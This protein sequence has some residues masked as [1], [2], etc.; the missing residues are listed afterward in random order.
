MFD[1]RHCDILRKPDDPNLY[2]LGRIHNHNVVIVCLPAGQTGASSAAAV[3]GQMRCQFTSIQH[4]FLVGVGGGVPG[5]DAAVRLGDVVISQPHMGHGGVVQYDF[6][7]STPSGF[8]R[9]GFVNAPP[10]I[11]LN[12]VS[13]LRANILEHQVH[14]SK[15][16]STLRRLRD[17]AGPDI[18]F[19]STYKHVG[20]SSCDSCDKD[21]VIHGVPRSSEDIVIHYGTIASGNQLIRD[22]ITRD[23]LSSQLGGV[24]CFEMEAAGFMSIF[25][26][27]VI[28]GICDYAD[29]HKSKKWQ[30]YA[31]ATA[32]IIAK[33]ILSILPI[34]QLAAAEEADFALDNPLQFL[35]L[36]KRPEWHLAQAGTAM[37]ILGDEEFLAWRKKTSAC[38]WLSGKIGSGKTFVTT[39]VVSHLIEASQKGG[40]FVAHFFYNHSSKFRLK[41]I[42]L[43]ESY[44]K[45]IL[46]FLEKTGHVCPQELVCA[47][48]RFYGPNRC[49]PSF[50]EIIERIFIPLGDFLTQLT[51][52]STYIVDG[53]DECESCER[54]LVLGTFR[55]MVQQRDA[56][57]VFISGRE[58]LYVTNFIEDSTT[59]RISNKDNKD[60]IREFIEWKVEAKLRE[61][62]LTENEY[63]LQDIKR[64]LNEKAD[65]IRVLWV[66]MQ[67]D[68]LWDECST[69]GDIQTALENLPR[70][71]DETY[72]R[73]LQRINKRQSRFAWTILRWVAAAITPF[74]V[75]QLREGLAINTNT[76]CLDRNQIPP[77]QEI[78][79]CCC[80]LITSNNGQILLTH[81]SVRQFLETRLPSGQFTCASFELYTAQSELG[82]LCVTHLTSADYGLGLQHCNVGECSRI[83][84]GKLTMKTLIEGPLPSW[85]HR[86]LPRPK[87]ATIVLPNRSSNPSSPS[88]TEVLSFFQYAKAHWAPLTRHITED[89]PNWD[90][91]RALALEPNLSWRLHPWQPLGESLDSH[92]SGLLGWAV[93]NHHVPLLHILLGLR[94]FKPKK[95]IFNVPFYHYDSLP[96]LHLASITGD[97]EIVK[98]LLQVCDLNK[99]DNNHRTSLHHAAERGHSDVIPLLIQKQGDLKVRDS[100]GRTALHFAAENGHERAVQ[101]LIDQGADVDQRD[102][103]RQT[104]IFLA[105]RNGH[106][107]II[108]TL[109]DRGADVNMQDKNKW[110]P[111][112]IAADY[113]RDQ[114]VRTL[115]ELGADINMKDDVGR[116][117]LDIAVTRALV[118]LS[119]DVDLNPI[120]N[121]A[122]FLA[123][124]QGNEAVLRVL[125]ACGEAVDGKDF[126]GWTP[127]MRAAASGH[128][129]VAKLLLENGA[130]IEANDMEYGW[131]PLS[132]A[133]EREQVAMIKLLLENGAD[134]EARHS[135]SRRTPLSW[136]V[137]KAQEAI[138]KLLLEKGAKIDS[139][140]T[141]Y[142]YTPLLWAVKKG[143]EAIINLLLE[144][145]ANVDAKDQFGRTPLSRAAQ[146]GDEATAKLLLE[147]G[148]KIEV[149]DE[150]CQT[151]LSQAI[152]A[153]N[154][155]MIEL[156]LEKG[157]HVE[158]KDWDIQMPFPSKEGREA[159]AELL[160]KKAADIKA[161]DR[162]HQTLL[163]QAAQ[164]GGA[165]I[166]KLLLENGADIEVKDEFR[167]TPLSRAATVGNQA[168]TKL[169]LEKGAHIETR[170]WDN[171]TPLSWAAEGGH[172]TVTELLL[173]KGA[174]IEA[175]DG[176]YNQTP[177]S[178]AARHGQEAVT[179]LLLEKGADFE[180]KDTQYN[181]TPLSW[182]AK[183]G[184]EAVAKLLLEKG[185]Y[186]QAKDQSGRTPLSW[187]VQGGHE[188]VVR[189]LLD[190]GADVQASDKNGRTPV[191]WAYIGGHQAIVK[192]LQSADSA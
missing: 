48:K 178:L 31:A 100:R 44:I 144:K 1:E 164:E 63:V 192:L 80:N 141:E 119:G 28:R 54:R 116:K 79:K 135:G 175:K 17:S 125:L 152:K 73:C 126:D 47:V 109:V 22:G 157:A 74:Q 6:G 111:L 23:T 10:T 56:Q 75:D 97:V 65:L 191:S 83:A 94:D 122:I 186:L 184:H 183:E 35:N 50:A 138:I 40:D 148:A 62:Q 155:A 60:D 3:M 187:A 95:D 127:L 149:K 142:S 92:Y 101:A 188:A 55:N 150:F 134:I 87:P 114:T 18:L 84:M 154:M 68:A 93:V 170:D 57:R 137:E 151:P 120:T 128:E 69:D 169:L 133:I 181:Q 145:G 21:L 45:Q 159:V 105:A 177:L 15:N 11:L 86:F 52:S 41:A 85:T 12:A 110:T 20:G 160:L 115:I 59:L 108:Q 124:Q 96:A 29:S 143:Q 51:P 26:G 46:G 58:D 5:D 9:T 171:R 49:H 82:A 8:I 153:G 165:V 107:R 117:A 139:E 24:L 19:Q 81:H 71:L 25:P 13:K 130:N 189:L 140:D 64:K 146:E 162:L 67:I 99:R 103:M 89:S 104:A 7:K 98:R 78:I 121:Q 172:E 185:A 166:T 72:A 4:T 147:K 91:F 167:Q 76:G 136:A 158:A 174:N 61:R 161:K 33:E 123:V 113:L 14:I 168:V 118:K 173:E 102:N 53:L 179:Q 38:L 129:A 37:W 2:T 163:S 190:N 132:W 176:E 36:S 30:A 66:S 34:T 88:D 112:F 106:K 70:S 77:R 182:A 156:L 27:L 131:T 16:L 42:H 90:K 32:A 39:T 180:T 43:F